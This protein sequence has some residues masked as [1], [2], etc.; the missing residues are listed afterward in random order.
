MKHLVAAIA[1]VTLAIILALIIKADVHSPQGIFAMVVGFPGVF[2][3][4]YVSPQQDNYGLMI[5]VNA[6]FYFGLGEVALR[7]GKYMRLR[8][9]RT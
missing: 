4:L 2:A 9:M 5:F 7:G 6:L 1:A 8:R 3:S